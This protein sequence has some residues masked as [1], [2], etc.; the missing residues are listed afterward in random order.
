MS[1]EFAFWLSLVGVSYPSLI[2]P[3]V[4]LVLRALIHRPV[5]KQPIA[6]S[7]SLLIPAFNEAEVIKSKISNALGLDYPKELLEIVV[8]SDGSTDA[9]VDRAREME[10]GKRVRVVAYPANRGKVRR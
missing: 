5:L 7:V 4:L 8:A 2:Y 1:A 10:D 6:P 3:V 9:T